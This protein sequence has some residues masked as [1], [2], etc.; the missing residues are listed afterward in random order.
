MFDKP[1]S[2]KE[3][4][5]VTRLAGQVAQDVFIPALQEHF[6]NKVYRMEVRL[7]KPVNDLSARLAEQER[8]LAVLRTQLA[9]LQTTCEVLLGRRFQNGEI[10]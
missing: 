2:E 4:I 10:R 3:F 8:E 6:N 9:T 7:E 1:L 5:A